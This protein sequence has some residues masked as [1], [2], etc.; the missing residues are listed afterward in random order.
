MNQAELE[1][2]ENMVIEL[3]QKNLA[4]LKENFFDIFQKIETLSLS[5]GS[6]EYQEQYS[7]EIMSG[8]FDIKNL[9]NGGFYYATNSYEDG[10]KRASYVN[11]SIKNSIDLL[12]KNKSTNTLA[13]PYGLEEVVP[14]V[15]FINKTVDLDN[16]NFQRI[17]KKIYIGVG[18]GYHIQEIDKNLESYTTLIIEPELEIFRLSLFTMD[19]SQF[20]KGSRKLFLSVGDDKKQRET[21]LNLLYS[22]HSYMNYNVKYYKL[23]NSHDYLQ[24][25]IEDYFNHNYIGAFPYKS[26]I[27]NIERTLGFIKEKDRFLIVNENLKKENIFEEKKVLL[28]SAG[29]S[30]DNY[31]EMIKVYQDKLIIV[32]VDVIVKKL[33]KHRIIPDI[34]FSIDP[35]HL[36][37]GYL[38]TEE[39]KYLKNSVI[40][41]LSQQHPDTMKVLRERNLHYYVSQFTNMIKAI[42]TLGS[43]PNVGT[44]SFHAITHF[45]AKEMFTIGNDA[46]FDQ[47]TGSRYSSD[48]SCP[49]TEKIDISRL[50]KNTISKEDILEVKGNLRETIKTNRSLIAFKYSYESILSVLKSNLCYEAYNLSDGAYIDG[51][52]PMTKE[53]FIKA[54]EDEEK[55]QLNFKNKFEQISKVIDDI[56]IEEDIK[57][58]NTIIKRV[59]NFQKIKIKDKDDFL[60]QKLDLMIWVL[61]KTKDLELDIVG[62]VFLDYTHLVDSYINF[63]LN[64]QQ[65]GIYKK[66]NLEHLR[67]AWSKGMSLVFKDIKKSISL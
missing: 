9:E 7:L 4:F 37:A 57:I 32:C 42:G 59:K 47:K 40:V 51:L 66:E 6:G 28:I 46:A 5:I 56:E 38:T 19:Y 12:R 14:I 53:E 22:Y 25:E 61:E 11:S 31:I 21:V 23:L 55:K 58:I 10:E 30:L 65:K 13:V 15:E 27:K 2:I 18:L 60:A 34:V 63:F 54:I 8:Y 33:E 36:C 16:V 29:P 67:D 48:S 44:F 1:Q 62:H 49:Q 45:G 26:V 20:N 64:L 39:P 3:Y 43:L 50:G 52:T 24:V 35:S 17:M 41:L